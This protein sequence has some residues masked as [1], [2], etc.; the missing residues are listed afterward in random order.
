MIRHGETEDNIRRAFSSSDTCLTER[1]INQIKNTKELLKSF[2]YE[3]IY[4]SPLKRTAET[5]HHLGLT[6]IE[7][8]RIKEVNLGI[9][10]GKTFE[11]ISRDYPDETEKWSKNMRD[12]KVP[13]GESML[14]VYNRVKK[15]L[16]EIS[17]KENTLLVAHDG[18]IK[19]AM[20]WVFDNPDYFYKFKIDNGSINIIS[21]E[22]GYKFIK[23]MNYSLG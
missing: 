2:Q 18:I 16:E 1:G 14:E 10:A 17:D 13:K 5:L 21:I 6:G 20:C 12:Y 19:L 8:P 4:Y 11:E 3:K 22:D 23:N 7:E 15:F 9:F